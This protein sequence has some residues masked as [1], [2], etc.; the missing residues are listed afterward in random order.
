LK[1]FWEDMTKRLKK[2]SFDGILFD[3]YPLSKKEI[4]KNHFPFFKEAHR[5]LKKGGILTYYSD[6][7]NKFSKEHLEKLKNSG[8]KD[9]KWESC[10]VNPPE[11]SM[12]WR[13]KTILAP[14]IKK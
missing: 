8:F 3:T 13:K 9:I 10:K 5:L 1:G 6:E 11:N 2:E 7:S 12:Y 14:I 4:H